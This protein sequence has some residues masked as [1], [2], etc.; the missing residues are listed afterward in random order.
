MPTKIPEIKQVSHFIPFENGQLHLRE[1]RPDDEISAPLTPV[2]LLHGAM[3]NGKVFYSQSGKGLACYLAQHG[4]PVYVLDTF[5]RGLSEPSL[6]ADINPEQ[7]SVIC[8]QLPLIHEWILHRHPQAN[9][10]HWGG[11]S[12]GG[13]LMAS[14]L[15]RF[16][17]LTA[18]VASLVCFGSKRTI[19][20]QSF[21][22]RLMVDLIWNRL[23]PTLA[24]RQGYFDA[25]QWRMGM[26]NESRASLLESID[27]VGG[28]WIGHQDGFDYAHAAKS[29]QW[30]P[31]WFF[32]GANDPVLGNPKD[33]RDMMAECGLSAAKYSLL[34]KAS[35]HLL[36]YGHADM[37]TS[38]LATMDHFPGLKDWWLTL[39]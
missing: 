18:K 36:D 32:A 22:K 9:K 38:P 27:W 8:Q 30:P 39:D 12:W 2:L 29:C 6:N 33:V 1:I 14:S 23:A 31:A 13:V 15:V 11:H 19:K 3:S 17:E 34:A 10:V 16:P 37:L 7:E 4:I 35:G 20:T 26:D 24:K 25:R 5:G 21:K 28:A